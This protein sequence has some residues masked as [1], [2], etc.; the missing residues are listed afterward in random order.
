VCNVGGEVCN[1]SK[2][3]TTCV[4]VIASNNSAVAQVFEAAA[5]LA[6][7]AS[8]ITYVNT[9]TATKEIKLPNELQ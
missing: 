4:S 9:N 3:F 7:N 2:L 8:Y 1:H 6:V 5:R